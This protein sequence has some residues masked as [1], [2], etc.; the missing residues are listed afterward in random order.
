[1]PLIAQ[2]ILVLTL[3]AI[4]VVIVIWQASRSLVGKRS[5]LGSCCAKGCEAPK[6]EQGSKT[7]FMPVE[8]LTLKKR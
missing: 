4:C 1:M 2:N 7:Q 3:V 6:P 5:R 8:M